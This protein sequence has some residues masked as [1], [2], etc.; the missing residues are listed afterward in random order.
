MARTRTLAEM[1]TDVRNQGDYAN[2]NVFTDAI[3]TE[4]INKGIAEVYELLVDASESYYLTNTTV[5][6]TAS[7][8]YV[9]APTDLYTLKAVDV[10]V[11]SD[12]VPLQKFDL[13]ERGQNKYV[14]YQGRYVY[15]LQGSNIYLE[16]TPTTSSDTLRIWYI[17]HAT[18][19]SSDS[20][21]FDGINGFEDLVIEKALYLCDK[22]DNRPL[23]DR[24]QEIARLEAR[25]RKNAEGRESDE[26]F[27]LP[28]YGGYGY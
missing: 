23:A 27:Y 20:D 10:L 12:Y 9:A 26:P 24:M 13:D 7:Q 18:K 2:S 25:V 6:T 17:P 1:R 22:R 3:L 21:T 11:G 14:R 28:D 19:L 5:T 16:P 15:R 8:A 4:F